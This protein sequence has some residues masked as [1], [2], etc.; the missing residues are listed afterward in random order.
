VRWS[1]PAGR[2]TSRSSLRGRASSRVTGR[3]LPIVAALLMSLTR[4][5][6]DLAASPICEVQAFYQRVF[7]DTPCCFWFSGFGTIMQRTFAAFMPK[8]MLVPPRSLQA[9]VKILR[10]SLRGAIVGRPRD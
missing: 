4:I 7:G 8:W 9:F 10:R 2:N 6:I 5:K 3:L 1:L